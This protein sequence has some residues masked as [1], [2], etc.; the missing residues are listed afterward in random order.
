MTVGCTTEL[1]IPLATSRRR[2]NHSDF[3]LC[4]RSWI[5]TTPSLLDPHYAKS[6]TAGGSGYGLPAVYRDRPGLLGLA[7]T[8]GYSPESEPVQDGSSNTAVLPGT[9]ATGFLNR[10]RWFDS[11]RGHD[12]QGRRLASGLAPYSAA[13]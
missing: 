13:I 11:D 1:D 5:P 2:Q 9:Q 4:H 12:T 3:S 7:R 10:V 8:P 6:P